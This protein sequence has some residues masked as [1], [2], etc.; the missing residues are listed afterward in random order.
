[1]N[2][3][4]IQAVQV[5]L[6]QME[7][8]AQTFQRLGLTAEGLV[9]AFI[10]GGDVDARP[11]QKLDEGRIGNADADDGHTLAVEVV[12]ILLY[13][14]VHKTRSFPSFQTEMISHTVFIIPRRRVNFNH[15]YW[16]S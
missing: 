7:G 5:I 3:V 4:L 16:L 11:D 14:G 10:T 6:P 9:G 1:E 8:D 2:H 12:Q 15:S 13:H